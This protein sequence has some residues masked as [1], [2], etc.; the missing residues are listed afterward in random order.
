MGLSNAANAHLSY[1]VKVMFKSAKILPVMALSLYFGQSYGAP[2]YLA[3]L[4]LCAGLSTVSAANSTV[5]LSGDGLGFAMVLASM[6][7]DAAIGNM[8]Q[9]TLQLK[10]LDRTD[11]TVQF[12]MM[13]YQSLIGCGVLFLICG[14]LGET[15][16]GLAFSRD[17]AALNG[18]M[19]LFACLGC[20]GQALV[21][22]LIK[23]FGIFVTTVAT[24]TRQFAT[25]LLSFLIFPKPFSAMHAFACL[26]FF[27]GLATNIWYQNRSRPGDGGTS[28]SYA[29][30]ML[31][32]GAR[33]CVDHVVEDAMVCLSLR[34]ASSIRITADDAKAFMV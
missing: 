1:P 26:L 7:A 4:L 28:P 31:G 6:M 32:E 25:V 15:T 23:E 27:A 17:S 8:Q 9:K 30:R 10:T 29:A 14:A 19:L 3:A 11:M 24:T 18:R 2:Q 33:A 12:D 16:E 21:V 20:V 5:A 13:Y 22:T 34:T